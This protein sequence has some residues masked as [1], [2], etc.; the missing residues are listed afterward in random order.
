VHAVLEDC[1]TA[2]M[3]V[4]ANLET[5]FGCDQVFLGGESAG[6]HLAASTAIRL[7][8]R[9]VERGRVAGMI[10]LYGCYD[11]AGTPSLLAAGPETLI[12]H[13]PTLA[14]ALASLLVGMSEEQKR[15]PT[16]SPLYA[17][18]RGL[19]PALMMVGDLDPLID[20]TLFLAERMAASGVDFELERIP[21]APHGFNRLPTRMARKANA[22][23]R[24]WVYGR[25]A[26]AER[27]RAV[28]GG[29][30]PKA[31]VA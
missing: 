26:L 9:G 28:L 13:G 10:L 3:W 22:Y 30:K 27:A 7:R 8:D 18:L 11:L 20:D 15:C 25:L 6:A 19:P 4:L 14:K 31:A 29:D 23:M 2:A 17:D 1:E 12:L 16:L 24:G 5:E 21:E